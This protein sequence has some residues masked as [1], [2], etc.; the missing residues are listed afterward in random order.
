MVEI[1]NHKFKFG[2]DPEIFV[3]RKDTAKLESAY[4]LIH[5]T[6]DQPFRVK[7]GAV[8]VDG[9]ALEFNIDP[10]DNFK[11]FNENINTVMDILGRMVPRHEFVIEP[12]AHFGKAYIDSQPEDAKRLGCDPDYN[13]YTGKANPR[14]D[15]EF[16]FRTASGHIHISWKSNNKNWPKEIDPLDPTHFEAC[17]KLVKVLDKYIGVP[18]VLWD[19]DVERRRLYGAAGAFRPKCYGEGWFGLEYRTLSNLWLKHPDTRALVFGNTLDA[20]KS[21]F[22]NY[23]E[24]DSYIYGENP[25]NGKYEK[26]PAAVVINRANEK[27]FRDLAIQAMTTDIRSPKYYREIREKKAG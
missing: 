21:L 22:D 13:A 12:V 20:I 25:D 23:D 11:E 5:G 19:K 27:G 9:M 17:C 18:S 4:G 10:V 3:K 16:P 8:Q 15:A 14:P 6:K 24:E 2:T 7:G 1:N 26:V